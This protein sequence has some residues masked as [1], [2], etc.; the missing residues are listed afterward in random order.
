M[1]PSRAIPLA[2]GLATL[3]AAAPA[4]A[5]IEAPHT[6]G[7][8]AQESTNILVVRVEKVEKGRNLIVFRKVKDL[9]GTHN[10]D[11]VKQNIGNAGF[12]PRES[13]TIM[14]WA[15]PGKIAVIFHNNSASETCIPNYWYQN[16]NG[17]EWWNLNHGEPYLLRSFCGD[18]QKLIAA[19]T[20]LLSG[21]EV[22]VPCMVDG[23]KDALQQGTAK[24]QRLRASLKLQDY[25]PKRDF[26]GWGDESYS[27]L[28]GMPGF[29]HIAALKRVDPDALGV[30]AADID[31]DGRPDPLLFGARQ[32]GLFQNGETAPSEVSLPY[33]GG[34]RGASW[35]DFDGDGKPDL[36]L[37]TPQ[38]PK[39]LANRGATFQDE[40][41][42]LPQ[43]LYSCPTAATWVDF[44]GDKR[45]DVL[46]A[47]GPLGFRLYR[48][49]L[50]DK[51][52]D[53]G[54]PPLLGPWH[55]IGP[56]PNDGGQGF[57]KAYPPESEIKLDAQY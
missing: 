48:N 41:S 44:D 6:L 12:S 36:L 30:V 37:A 18:P 23:N 8:V 50:G 5:Y 2:V 3:L 55:L 46:L 54:G 57:G 56:F 49:T 51:D 34:A 33:P 15:E 29:T 21:Q 7:R 22:V 14:A 13:Q 53:P 17:G 35:A 43:E 4:S 39:L 26:V 11:V 40:S 47:N 9:K 19:V 31:G 42:R 32:L 52:S 45:P 38:G 27:R 1:S 20:T 24:I 10:G 16:A 28:Q 25:E